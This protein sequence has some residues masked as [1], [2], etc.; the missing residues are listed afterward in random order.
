MVT[1][2]KQKNLASIAKKT[3]TSKTKKTD[4][5]NTVDKQARE[6]VNKLVEEIDSAPTKKD[7]GLLEISEEK[8]TKNQ[9]NDIEWLQEELSRLSEEN[10]KLLKESKEA[11][12][13]YKKLY[14]SYEVLKKGGNGGKEDDNKIIPDS[15]LKNSVIELFIDIQNNFQGRNPEKTRYKQIIP[16]PFMNKMVKLFPFLSE[17]KNF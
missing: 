16:V 1:K 3:T 14:S 7:D 4:E 10:E 11:K 12:E 5:E 9:L 8:P 6:R 17:Y 2:R 13:E 15:Q